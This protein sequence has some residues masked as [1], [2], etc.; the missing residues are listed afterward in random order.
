MR[1]I[2]VECE[3]KFDQMWHAEENDVN[4]PFG[5]PE[6]EDI[7]KGGGKVSG[8][9]SKDGDGG[10]IGEEPAM[11]QEAKNDSSAEGIHQ[12]DV[13][14]EETICT[15]IQNMLQQDEWLLDALAPQR[16]G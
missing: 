14:D 1:R 15:D 4:I 7:R 5:D 9:D 13:S 12:T 8:G 16:S 3:V 10:P 11:S 2:V 6:M